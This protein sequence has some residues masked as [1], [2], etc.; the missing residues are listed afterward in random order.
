ME[1]QTSLV[2]HNRPLLADLD[3]D[4][5][6]DVAANPEPSALDIAVFENQGGQF[7][8]V[9]DP[10]LGRGDRGFV[11]G[12]IDGDGLTDL[13]VPGR[14]TLVYRRT[15]PGL[16]YEAATSFQAKAGGP[17]QAADIDHDGDQDLLLGTI[18]RNRTFFG[19]ETGSVQQ[20]GEGTPGSGGHTPVLGA[21]GVFRPGE[22]AGITVRKARGGSLGLL[23]VGLSEGDGSLSIPGLDVYVGQPVLLSVFALDGAFRADGEGSFD[24]PLDPFLGALQG[25]TFYHQVLTLDVGAPRWFTLSNGLRITYGR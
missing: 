3:D 22:S 14:D 6:L 23:V 19:P 2:I 4:G 12:D 8:Q 13:V 11:A 20:F 5:D 18:V 17:Q 10:G 1:S 15:G 7:T 25:L 16:Q 21:S 9:A 24:L